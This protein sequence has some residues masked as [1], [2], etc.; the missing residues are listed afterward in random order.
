MAG[1]IVV[2]RAALTPGDQ[3]AGRHTGGQRAANGLPPAQ[4]RPEAGGQPPDVVVFDPVA[5]LQNQQDGL[6]S[7]VALIQVLLGSLRR[8]CAAKS[9]AHTLSPHRSACP[10]STPSLAPNGKTWRLA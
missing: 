10:S 7:S 5:G 2:S 6:G 8:L 1:L 9:L 4:P 3:A